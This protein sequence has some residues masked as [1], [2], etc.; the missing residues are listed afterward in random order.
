MA[1]EAENTLEEEGA[2]VGQ[3]TRLEM[4]L[5][6]EPSHTCAD[7]RAGGESALAI[8]AARGFTRGVHALLVAGAMVDYPGNE[9]HTPMHRAAST[10][11]P[12]GGGKAA[13]AGPGPGA[14]M[15]E[16]L[17]VAGGDVNALNVYGESPLHLAARAGNAEV[18]KHLIKAGAVGEAGDV[19]GHT[20]AHISAG[21]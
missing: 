18:V 16:M 19:G 5:A 6:T 3:P 17:I 21:E 12:A 4:V 20:P 9:G 11:P 10:P 8:A 15:V 2:A 1:N 7:A 14:L 13:G